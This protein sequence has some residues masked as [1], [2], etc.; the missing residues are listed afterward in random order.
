M[1]NIRSIAE[2][3]ATDV[4]NGG[5]LDAIDEIFTPGHVYHDP[6]L[7][8]LPPGPAGVRQ[9][10]TTYM[11]GFPDARVQLDEIV[12]AGPLVIARWTWAGINT[13]PLMGISPT[14]RPARITGI[15]W[16]R[17]SGDR[18]DETWVAADTL[19]L[20]VQLGIVEL[21]APALA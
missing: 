8:S 21:P 1:T 16:L 3:Y 11:G 19:G 20:M 4:W 5:D 2:R 14:G 18:I 15:H 12:V 10:V 9:R 7:P 6:A 17:F 13:G